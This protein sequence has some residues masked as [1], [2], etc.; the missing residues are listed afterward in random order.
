[1]FIKFTSFIAAALVISGA[2][3]YA[4]PVAG[5]NVLQ[6]K[7]EQISPTVQ[8]CLDYNLINCIGVPFDESK[9]IDFNEG[10]TIL[11]KVI[12]SVAVPNGYICDLF[13]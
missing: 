5:S 12:S 1:M 11:N 2:A 6:A 10:R 4:N 13:E 3:V 9:C 7:S 8:L